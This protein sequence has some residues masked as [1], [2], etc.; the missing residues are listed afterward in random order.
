[1]SYTEEV[2]HLVVD[3]KGKLSHLGRIKTLDGC[4]CVC[5]E[6]RVVRESSYQD[7]NV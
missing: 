6:I 3:A 2:Y 7:G 1:M 5:L 4:V